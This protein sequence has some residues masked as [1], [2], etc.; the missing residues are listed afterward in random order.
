MYESP[1]SSSS[2]RLYSASARENSPSASSATARLLCA[3][4]LF[5]SCWTARS[6]RNAASRHSPRRATEVPNAIW[7]CA[8]S[9]REYDE[10]PVVMTAAKTA[11][12][13]FLITSELA[14]SYPRWGGYYRKGGARSRNFALSPAAAGR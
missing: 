3:R 14:S 4:A 13:N 2:A 7:V 11:S 9:V 10:Q 12:A 5:G 1:E 6:N 8:L